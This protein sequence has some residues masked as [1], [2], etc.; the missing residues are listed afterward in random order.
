MQWDLMTYENPQVSSSHIYDGIKY[1]Y[2]V[3]L[4]FYSLI[5]QIHMH[6]FEKWTAVPWVQISQR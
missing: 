6:L 5:S 3:L 1:N 4:F 2:T